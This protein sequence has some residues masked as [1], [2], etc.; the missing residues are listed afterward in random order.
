MCV[1]LLK[2]KTIQENIHPRLSQQN[3]E[4]LQARCLWCS[5]YDVIFQQTSFPQHMFAAS[6]K[7]QNQEIN[8]NIIGE[9][10]KHGPWG[11]SA[12]WLKKNYYDCRTLPLFL[13]NIWTIST[14]NKLDIWH[15]QN[16]F[17]DNSY[18]DKN[19]LAVLLYETKNKFISIILFSCM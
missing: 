16:S 19:D 7:F 18:I 9:L 14:S 4:L 17:S 1:L 8:H 12:R 15:C 11:S 6:L 10:C 5:E 3:G 2:A 13:Y